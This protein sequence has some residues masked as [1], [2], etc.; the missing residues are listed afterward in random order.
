M[1]LRGI[2][3][4]ISRFQACQDTDC[5]TENKI[6]KRGEMRLGIS[7]DSDTGHWPDWGG[8][9]TQQNISALRLLHDVDAPARGY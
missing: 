1:P 8:V 2:L 4:I 9:G 7:K 3:M 5:A 6:A